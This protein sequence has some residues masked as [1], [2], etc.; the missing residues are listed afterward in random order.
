MKLFGRSSDR[1][2]WTFTDS[3]TGVSR[4]F[5]M[6]PG[7]PEAHQDWLDTEASKQR[8]EL[9]V[10]QAVAYKILGALVC[11]DIYHKMSNAGRVERAMLRKS[12]DYH[13]VCYYAGWAADVAEFGDYAGPE[14]DS[15][16]M[17]ATWVKTRGY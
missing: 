6:P 12:S 8:T 15:R 13:E 7:F 16:D 3:E 1:E 11:C 17:V 2:T 9:Q 4:T 5:E 14:L 10:R